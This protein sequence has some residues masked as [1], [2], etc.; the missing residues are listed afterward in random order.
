M[1]QIVS[2]FTETVMPSNRLKTR[3]Q[4]FLS[5]ADVQINGSRPWDISVHDRNLYARVLRE[6]SI[7]LGE[8]YMDGWWDCAELDQFFFKLFN[9]GIER[10]MARSWRAITSSLKLFF[11]NMQ[12]KSRST[13][14]ARKHYDL[15]NESFQCMLDLRMV[16]TCGWWEHAADLNEAQEAKL[17]FVCR[18]LNLAPGMRLLDI[19]CGSESF[20]KFVGEKYGVKVVGITLSRQQLD[21][22]RTLCAGLPVELRLQD[23]RDLHDSFDRVVSLGMFEHV[24]NK[25]YQTFFRVALRAIR[26]SGSLFLDTIGSNRSVRTTDPWME[27]YI[28]PNSH[29]PSIPQIGAALSGCFVVEEWQN[30]GRLTTGR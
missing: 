29:L 27:R 15:G 16:Y 25:N 4:E 28:F 30:W 24:G 12:T 9:S 7:G 23:H 11:F 2:V 10:N 18:K 8:S 21:L 17:D 26:D 6:G 20:A 14:V 3:M 22:A 5:L 1:S 13:N 19:G